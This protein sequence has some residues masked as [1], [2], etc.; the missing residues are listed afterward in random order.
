M[1]FMAVLRS[2]HLNM[3]FEEQIKS[4]SKGCMHNPACMR[5]GS[6]AGTALTFLQ[7]SAS[8]PPHELDV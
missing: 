4:Y 6:Q 1:G 2:A 8:A 3:R 5:Q 7:G